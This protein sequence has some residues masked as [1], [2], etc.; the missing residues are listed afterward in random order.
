MHHVEKECI[1]WNEMVTVLC[2]CFITNI[3]LLTATD[4]SATNSL[5]YKIDFIFLYWLMKGMTY[6]HTTR[7]IQHLL[8]IIIMTPWNE[9]WNYKYM[10]SKISFFLRFSAEFGK[11]SCPW[12]H[13]RSYMD[14]SRTR[15]GNFEMST[16]HNIYL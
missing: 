6:E 11:G 10:M 13:Y 5:Y 14:S 3:H 2:H 16:L 12:P 1:N 7:H 9:L 4:L 8:A 15:K